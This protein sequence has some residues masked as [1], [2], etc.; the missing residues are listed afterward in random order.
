MTAY[1]YNGILY[2]NENK[3]LLK[4]PT[5]LSN[6]KLILIKKLS[7]VLLSA[8]FHEYEVKKLRGNKG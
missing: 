6:T 2:G 5:Y 8:C 4:V 3:V 1:L 7:R